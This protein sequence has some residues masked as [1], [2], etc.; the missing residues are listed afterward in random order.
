MPV[1]IEGAAD[2]VLIAGLFVLIGM[3]MALQ[4]TF[5]PMLNA[6]G[7]FD[8]HIPGIGKPFKGIT[9]KAV[10][11]IN[12][13]I[14]RAIEASHKA[15][16]GLFAGLAWSIQQVAHAVSVVAQDTEDA[17]AY[18]VNRKIPTMV[19]ALI[20][21]AELAAAA[22]TAAAG[23]ATH[24]VAAALA[25]A[26]AYVGDRIVQVERDINEAEAAAKAYAATNIAAAAVALTH[27]AGQM[28][29]DLAHSIDARLDKLE[30]SVDSKLAAA[31]AAAERVARNA[32]SDALDDAMSV[33]G[34]IDKDIQKIVNAA[35]AK[36]VAAGA[37]TDAAITA[38]V[39][40]AVNA[41]LGPAGDLEAHIQADI[42][43]A[44]SAVVSVGG[45]TLPQVQ[46]LINR[47][48][49]GIATVGGL[50]IGE[51]QSLIDSAITDAI[52]GGGLIGDLLDDVRRRIDDTL[53]N[54]D[55]GDLAA[56][57][58]AAA[59]ATALLALT[60][61]ETGLE[62]ASCRS[63]VKGICGTSTDAWDG[64]LFGL[65]AFSAGLS[66][67]E[68]IEIGTDIVEGIETSEDFIA[69]LL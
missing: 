50:T 21:N 52:A 3:L 34:V 10:N 56:I 64:L 16:S 8:T 27:G 39:H 69:Q 66:L 29:S 23:S 37:A 65:A 9:V 13:G 4:H 1:V 32:V 40:A 6:L 36:A 54:L 24:S 22:A 47:A 18:L 45:V 12:N 15:I 35:I 58:A 17:L 46:D 33:G 59:A 20:R 31:T 42:S 7:N 48:V 25:E 38:A 30:G 60:L 55:L 28:V 57:G 14:G 43:R 49:S 11:A 63:K 2:L 5:V 41:A 68:L 61:T 19:A 67:E 26:K 44:I 53:A 62:N 51:V